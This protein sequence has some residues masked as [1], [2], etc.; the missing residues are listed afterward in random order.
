LL[1]LAGLVALALGGA[2]RPAARDTITLNMIAFSN[3]Q[4]GLDVLIANFERVNPNV[5]INITYT[6][7]TTIL[8]QVETTE[9]AAGNAPDLL[10]VQPACGT[11][12]SVCVLAKDGYLAPMISK[13]WVKWLVP[14]VT[15]SDKYGGGLFTFSAQVSPY[16]IFT[17]DDLF[18]KLGLSVPQTFPQLLSVCQKAKAAGTVALWSSGDAS[19]IGR[20]AE[21]LAV[22]PVYG[23]DPKW[24]SELKA[25][26][27]TFDGTA[28]WHTAM[29][30]LV[31][32]N[33][34]GC[35]QPG[36]TS[37]SQNAAATAFAQGQG[38]M[39]DNT[40]TQK[41]FI[42]GLHPQFSYSFH[43]LPGGTAT[44]QTVTALNLNMS[45]AVNAHS[46][47]ANQAAAQAFIDFLARPKQ[48]DLYAQILGGITQYEFLKN[49]VP[50]FMSSMAPVFQGDKYAVLPDLT[51]WNSAV[52]LA[53]SQSIGL[54][55][56]QLSIDDVLNGMDVAW[57]QG[58]S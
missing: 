54:L 29:Q 34:A 58:P 23:A 25:G 50:T 35:F 10:W 8:S 52:N 22:A 44:G 49:E 12:I 40:S 39:F 20:L 5:K 28:G 53:L 7:T 55:T 27:V 15:S 46:S 17:N 14:L 37:Y 11:R 57:K 41:G 4:P 16:G 48:T 30:E 19:G 26:K 47:A 18:K 9:L 43:V 31:Q 42:D 21:V 51:W 56:G 33:Q 32:L 13:R 38:L 2:A 1:A 24:T 3:A 6:A 45:P 36:L